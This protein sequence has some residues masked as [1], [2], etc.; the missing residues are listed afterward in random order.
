MIEVERNGMIEGKR[1][2]GMIEMK[3]IEV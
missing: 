3:K 2:N 1:R